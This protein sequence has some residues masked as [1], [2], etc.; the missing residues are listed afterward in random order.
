M[1]AEVL[2]KTKDRF[3]GSG[4]LMNLF[5]FF[6]REFVFFVVSQTFDI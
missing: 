6:E 4:H 1:Y 2:Y 5:A 3:F